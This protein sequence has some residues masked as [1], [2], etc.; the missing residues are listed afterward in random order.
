MPVFFSVLAGIIPLSAKWWVGAFDTL[1]PPCLQVGVT[2]PLPPAPPPMEYTHR[3]KGNN[4][5]TAHKAKCRLS[6]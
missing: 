5:E 3:E 4:K 2:A 6:Q 1:C